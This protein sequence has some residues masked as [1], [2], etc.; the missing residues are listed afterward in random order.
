MSNNELR[1][2]GEKYQILNV[3][4][5]NLNLKCQRYKSNS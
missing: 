3:T 1:I 4:V 5:M 2:N